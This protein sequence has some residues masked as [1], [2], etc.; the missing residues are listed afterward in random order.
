MTSLRD[1]RGFT[2]V[3]VMVAAALLLGGLLATMQML[4]VAAGRTTVAQ[5]REGATNLAREVLESAN[6][7]DY[8]ALTPG[9]AQG[10]LQAAAGVTGDWR[11][12]RRGFTYRVSA[13]GC[14]VDDRVDGFAAA[15]AAG[16]DFCARAGTATGS[17]SAP[18]DY[19]RVTVTVAWTHEG[20]ERTMRQ[21]TV[22]NN[23]GSA[24]GPGV[25]ALTTTSGPIV[26]SPTVTSVP[27][28]V[29]VT[30][31]PDTTEAVAVDVS[32]DGS[33]LGAATRVSATEWRYDFA[34]GDL[35][36]AAYVLGF[37]AVDARG[38]SRGVR[39]TSI[40]LNRYIARPPTAL[41]ARRNVRLLATG[42]TTASVVDLAW[43]PSE[44]RDVIGYRVLRGTTPV[45]ETRTSGAGYGA[46]NTAFS[47]TTWRSFAATKDPLSCVDA[48]APGGSPVYTV[49][50]L[51][52]DTAD[53][54]VREG[55]ASTAVTA[56]V[57]GTQPAR[58]LTPSGT[59][60]GGVVTLA[61]SAPTGGTAGIDHY[62]IYR[63]GSGVAARYDR[64]GSATE[65]TYT[66]R[67]PP[68][69]GTT[70]QVVAVAAASGAE[71]A[72]SDAVTP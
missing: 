13:T 34:V 17:D 48:D 14:V 21:S 27:V 11:V 69:A 38:R 24:A 43:T 44:D 20:R 68:A 10:V 61:W 9:A 33:R 64:T 51:D 41:V 71:S 6:A 60:A 23:P 28:T 72:L 50:A 58:P 30:G 37:K 19:R 12:E 70:Y 31:P 5:G 59:R 45:C 46:V 2:L 53:G 3:E 66:D 56:G 57:A 47:G 67:T 4:D 42:S 26:T 55:P 32:V 39:I 16:G 18:D 1:Q 29:A 25:V 8:D 63:G 65:L 22:V 36:D 49:T 62:R 54:S 7:V 15:S 52:T 40:T 35:P